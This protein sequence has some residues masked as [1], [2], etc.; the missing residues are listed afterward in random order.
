MNKA[1]YTL[2]AAVIGFYLLLFAYLLM[3]A[4][5]GT[6]RAWWPAQP[7]AG[8]I[9]RTATAARNLAWTRAVWRAPLAPEIKRSEQHRTAIAA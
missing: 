2:L 9:S 6:I 1:L 7:R 3:R 8:K 4:C 5:V